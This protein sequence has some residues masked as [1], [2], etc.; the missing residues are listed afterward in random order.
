MPPETVFVHSSN[1]LDG[2]GQPGAAISPHEAEL[3]L[4]AY[5]QAVIAVAEQVAPAVVSIA[6]TRR[7]ALRTPQ[8]TTPY[9][10]PATGSGFLITPDGYILTNSH[11]VH[12][13]R[14]LEATLAD[15]RTLP[16]E[17]VGDDPATDLA[18]VRV[19]AGGLPVAGL[20]DSDRLRVGQLVIAIGNPYGFQASVTT[21]VIS[22]LGRSLRSQ[23]GRLIENVIQTDV[24]LNPG[25]SGGPLV[26][27]HARVIGVNTA[28]IAGAQGMS[29][30]IP[31]NTARWIA[32]LL[33]KEGR[34]RRAFLGIT[35]ELRPVPGRLAR[36]QRLVRGVGIA[37]IQVAPGGPADRA[38]IRPGDLL[39]S[40]DS[41][42][43]AGI[44][45]LHRFL[46]RAAIGATVTVG[47]V[48]GGHLL[49]LPV[50]LAPE[51][52][53]GTSPSVR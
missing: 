51:P 3:L 53:P 23:S 14:R 19:Q 20:G 28:I 47:V 22:A 15:G 18:V 17:L 4:D 30:A 16:A 48:R 38:G 41:L 21:G 43:L 42:P 35:A 34:V 32:G 33:I 31:A 44:D 52:E 13:A 39:V 2:S 7:G 5:S 9:D 25:N 10:L 26:D 40:I 1:M 49:T 27:S 37:V 45:D 8:G 36:E 6:A 50:T 46:S 29:F 11:V 12:G 24:A